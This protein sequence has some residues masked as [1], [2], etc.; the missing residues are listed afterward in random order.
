V[1]AQSTTAYQ[2]AINDRTVAAGNGPLV[3]VKAVEPSGWTLPSGQT[4]KGEVWVQV[5][6]QAPG[7]MGVSTVTL[8]TDGGART[9]DVG[10]GTVSFPA[11]EA[12]W[13]YATVEGECA[14]PWCDGKAWGISR[15]LWLR[16]PV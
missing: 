12:H 5:E 8:W 6:V 13:A 4:S 10:D 2:R 9:V 16:G 14:Q 15:V 7:W 11:F 3:R 1:G